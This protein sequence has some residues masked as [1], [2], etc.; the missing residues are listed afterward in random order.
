MDGKLTMKVDTSHYPEFVFVSYDEDFSTQTHDVAVSLEAGNLVG[1]PVKYIR[2]DL[3]SQP[4]AT[5]TGLVTVGNGVFANG[6]M[7]GFVGIGF[8]FKDPNDNRKR[9]PICRRSQAEELLAAKDARIKELDAKLATANALV[10]CCCGDPVD[11]HHMWSGHSPVDQYHYTMKQMEE[12]LEAAEKA[13]DHWIEQ[14]RINLKNGQ[15]AAYKLMNVERNIED[16][17]R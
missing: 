1:E 9:E 8:E 3:C 15:E 10:T 2:H 13:R 4:V 14:N 17:T 6:E 7:V 11:A 16:V 5:D 12:K